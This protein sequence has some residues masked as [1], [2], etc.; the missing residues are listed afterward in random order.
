MAKPTLTLFILLGAL[1][2][3]T[4]L[5]IDMYLP[6]IPTIAHE[7][8]AG[9]EGVQLTVSL[10]LGGF[11]LGQL[12]YGPLADSLGRRPVILFGLALF[13]LSSLGCVFVTDLSQLLVLRFLQATG[14]AAG[15]VVVNA[16]LR[17]LFSGEDL[18]RAMSLVIL[19]MTLAPLVAP[20]LGSFLLGL[21]WHVIF[22]LL[23][24]LGAAL[25]YMLYRL[26]P[27]T[28]PP[29]RRRPLRPAVVLGGFAGVLRH[30]VAMG[31]L[32][33]GILASAGMFAFISGSP[34]VYIGFFGLSPLEYGML[35]ALNVG[36]MMLLTFLNTRLIRRWGQERMLRIGLFGVALAAVLLLV[37]GLTGLGGLVGLVIP[38]V[39]YVGQ[40]GFIG[41]NSMSLAMNH[42][43]SSAGTASAL[44]GTLRFGCGALAGWGV[45]LLPA[46]S[47]LP[48]AG[49]MALCGFCAL[50]LHLWYGRGG[51]PTAEAAQ[52]SS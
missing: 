15:A 13:S 1:A 33:P 14:G 38:V 28:L 40:L 11:A 49:G 27:E 37:V 47:P 12:V 7:L 3:L 30:R 10:F 31:H 45:N 50:G 29:E 41:A 19:T 20:M 48:M 25:C 24:L 9:V 51:S 39:L 22:G 18:V 35:F 21:G 4:P 36:L 46:S 26:V 23:A 32:L 8:G 34:Y 2:G 43:G 16:L 52:A 6:A 44:A 42:F 17:D 5:A